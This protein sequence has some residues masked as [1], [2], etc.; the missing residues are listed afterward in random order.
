MSRK[1][2]RAVVLLIVVAL[3]GGFGVYRYVLATDSH[4]LPDTIAMANGRIEVQRVDVSAKLPGRVA[5]I[6]VREGDLVAAG[7]VIATLDQS[8]TLAELAAAQ[9][10]VEQAIQGVAQAR[11][12]IASR[13]AELELA[14]VQL[15][16]AED[17]R[18]RDF[19]SQS[20][21]DQRRAG[22][23]VAAAAVEAAKA[24]LGSAQAAQKVA[25]AK[26]TQI[27]A[28]INDLVLK[29]P[30]AGRVEYKL[31]Q[32]GEVVAA[33]G[34][35]VTLLDLS[36]VYMTVFL[37]TSSVGKVKFGSEARIVLDAAP[38]Y[39]IPASVSFVAAEAQFTPKTVETTSEREK[40][41]YRVKVAVP[42]DLLKE[43]RDYV[44]SGL[45]GDA[46]VRLGADAAWP[47]WLQP[48][49]PDAAG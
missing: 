24:S 44:K 26:V 25:E 41:M 32:P 11:A 14:D 18:T 27:K 21:A 4:A 23:D 16:R 19:S 12:A 34:R 17:L 48:R 37:P 10:S 39:V 30:I 38:E 3:V 46:Y 43:Y 35:V 20:E 28:T 40:L 45:T 2:I 7:D 33:G 49:L 29:A 42:T 15:K 6:D 5:S 8:E 13:Q 1:L 22:R 36:D 47:D 31:V 9:A